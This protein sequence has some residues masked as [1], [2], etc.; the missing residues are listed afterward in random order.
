MSERGQSKKH[1]TLAAALARIRAQQQEI[2][3]LKVLNEELSLGMGA[4][5]LRLNR[6][7][8]EG[9]PGDFT[10]ASWHSEIVRNMVLAAE[11]RDH[12]TAAHLVRCGYF[13][14]RLAPM[15]GCDERLTRHL[16]LASPM[17]DVGK[18]AIPDF[19]LKKSGALDQ[20]ER[21]VMEQHTEYG[22]RI[23]ADSE[24]PVLQMASQ[25]ALTHHEHFDGGGYPHGLKGEEIPLAGRIVAI[26]DVFD[27]L[28]MDRFYRR[29]MG[30]EKALE[31]I[32]E[33]RGRQFDPRVSDAFFTVLDDLL[34][35][36][37]QIS[38][39]ERPRFPGGA[40]DDAAGNPL[41]FYDLPLHSGGA[42]SLQ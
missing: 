19:V 15:C 8:V 16:L 13:T 35:M 32:R 12:D 27:A 22:A 33:G 41:D 9:K 42:Q 30:V 38:R 21:Q 14:A 28:V 29:A 39:G 26:V 40:F 10:E 11:Y 7:V 37:E 6:A 2:E 24:S 18:I 23:L 34:E 20:H 25:I 31:I 4:M 17:H 3:R 36:H 1:G 5:A